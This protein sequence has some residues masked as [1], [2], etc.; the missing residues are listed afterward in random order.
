MKF[1]L[2]QELFVLAAA[3][4]FLILG[5][6]A[7]VQKSTQL[8]LDSDLNNDGEVNMHDFSIALD[9]VDRIQEEMRNRN[10]PANVI[11]DVYPDVPPY[12]PNN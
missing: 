8:P 10:H 1:T 4:V 2:H 7:G 11:E 5:Y 3:M 12:S 9:L 6:F